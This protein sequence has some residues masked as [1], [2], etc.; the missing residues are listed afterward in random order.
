MVQNVGIATMA[1]DGQ[2]QGGEHR[3]QQGDSDQGR[4]SSNHRELLSMSE[5]PMCHGEQSAVSRR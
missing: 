1:M 2:D 4:E 5:Q 3:Q